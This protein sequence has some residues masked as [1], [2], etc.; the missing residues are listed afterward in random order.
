MKE[1]FILYRSVFEGLKELDSETVKRLMVALGDYALDGVE[2]E[3]SGIEYALF[4]AWK[5]SIDAAERRRQA[6]AENG[7]KGGRPT[8]AKESEENPTK[9][10]E[11]QNNPTKTEKNPKKPKETQENPSESEKNLTDTITVTVTGTVT[12][13]E[14]ASDK[15]D[16]CVSA[17]TDTRIRYADM[18]RQWNTLDTYG[19][20]QI[21]TIDGSRRKLVHAR[22]K[23]YGVNVVEDI[24]ERIRGSDFLQ[25]RAAGARGKPFRVTFDWCVRPENCA[26]IL[27][28]NYDDRRD[29]DPVSV[30][31]QGRGG[32]DQGT[33][34]YFGINVPDDIFD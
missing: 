10:K 2:P 5:A 13:T 27:E 9:P 3:L 33:G 8:K 23:Q 14:E 32:V 26:K 25:G 29:S 28:G 31:G 6:N 21:K 11:T 7:Q 12:D 1:S 22:V 19:I 17:G 18:I 15:S 20:P 30:V 4:T 24:V 34:T 16:A